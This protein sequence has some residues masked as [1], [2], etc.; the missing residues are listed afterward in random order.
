MSNDSAVIGI[1]YVESIPRELID[2]FLNEV[3]DDRIEI[4]EEPRPETQFF[5]SIEWFIPTAVFLYVSKGY[6]DGFLQAAGTDHYER[7]KK[8]IP[9][10][11]T[12]LSH[13]RVTYLASAN[14]KLRA[15]NPFTGAISLLGEGEGNAFKLMFRHEADETE[16]AQS[17]VA[18]IEFLKHFHSGSAAS[19]FIRDFEPAEPIERLRLI[20]FD[21]KIQKLRLLDPK[22]PQS[23]IS[24]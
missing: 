3:S 14:K 15:D 4:I 11:F 18:F 9:D 12:R 8:A 6:F 2:P 7:L 24:Q 16:I 10:W 19:D 17:I 23:P 1:S 20:Y 13:I 21:V 5:A 22:Q